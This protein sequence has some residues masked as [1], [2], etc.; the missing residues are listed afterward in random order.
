MANLAERAR[1][2][3]RGKRCGFALLTDHRRVPDPLPLLTVLPPGSL[4]VLRHYGVAGRAALARELSRVCRAHR[5]V[6]L[7]GGD[8]DLAI[9][10]RAGLHLPE[11]AARVMGPRVRLWHRRTGR[12]LS[13]AAHGRVALERAAKAGADFAL[14]SPVFAT[15]SHPDAAPL[16]RLR[17]RCLVHGVRVPVWALGG[18]TGETI[19]GLRDAGA[20]GAAT[21]GNLQRG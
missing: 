2:L 3:N 21:V 10:T 6:F 20:A 9:A 16:G 18:I 19:R 4:V 7:I 14:L 12:P 13:I 11:S 5:L 8:I 15:A 1:R 17:F